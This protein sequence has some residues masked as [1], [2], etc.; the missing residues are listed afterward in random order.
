MKFTVPHFQQ[1]CLFGCNIGGQSVVFCK[2]Q[3]TKP[4][5]SSHVGLRVTELNF[6]KKNLQMYILLT[7]YQFVS[8]LLQVFY[9]PFVFIFLKTKHDYVSCNIL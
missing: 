9:M 6:T 2:F 8:Y 7:I 1:I 3:G 5:L 4:L